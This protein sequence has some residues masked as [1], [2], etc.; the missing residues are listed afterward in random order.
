M[1]IDLGWL[2]QHP[3]ASRE[4]DL[5]QRV[6][7]LDL[8][9]ETVACLEP[10]QARVAVVSA[11]DRMVATVQAR[12]LLQLQCGRCLEHYPEAVFTEFSFQLREEC[13]PGAGEEADEDTVTFCDDQ[14]D[15]LPLVLEHLVL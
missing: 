9:G 6:P 10:V 1:R 12:A 5:Q 13:E 8:G 11:G 14:F 4:F 3:G 15:V 2:K 7:Q